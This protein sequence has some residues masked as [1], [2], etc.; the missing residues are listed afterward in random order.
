MVMTTF[1]GFYIV[2]TIMISFSL[3]FKTSLC[4]EIPQTPSY[5]PRPLSSYE[6]YLSN[7]ASKLKPAECG[8]EI[9]KSIFVQYEFVSY[10]CC[11]SLVN[12]V[13]HTC[14]FDMTNYAVKLPMFAKNKKEILSRGEKVWK[15]C[16]QKIRPNLP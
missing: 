14:H 5:A 11:L 16:T 3:F 6:K 13:G 8:Q 7:C 2:V 4:S 10:Y 15:Y 12:D 9:F 1:N